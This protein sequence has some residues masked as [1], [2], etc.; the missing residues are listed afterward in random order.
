MENRMKK[1]PTPSELN[2]QSSISGSSDNDDSYSLKGSGQDEEI[3]SSSPSNVTQN[4]QPIAEVF[5]PQHKNKFTKRQQTAKE[6]V[7]KPLT[8]RAASMVVGNGV[9]LPTIFEND[10]G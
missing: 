3:G 2:Q 1:F 8:N 5:G 9:P 4:V 7:M 6:S 10:K